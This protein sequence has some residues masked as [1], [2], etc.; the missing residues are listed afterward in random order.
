MRASWACTFD[1]VRAGV[2][3]LW[4]NIPPRTWNLG[5]EIAIALVTGLYSGAIV[6]R[7]ARFS[8]LK[9]EALRL[10][11]G[12]DTIPE[13][14]ALSQIQ[15]ANIQFALISSDLYYLGHTRAGDV[16]N[17]VSHEFGQFIGAQQIP[18]D[19]SEY[20]EK[21]QVMIRTMPPS[22]WSIFKPWISISKL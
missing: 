6:A 15:Q 19:F 10:A 18:A 12:I 11:R 21:W 8:A 14:P 5:I 3:R 13:A 7:M 9:N 1:E 2:Y 20:Y 17:K 4:D 22:R 16:L